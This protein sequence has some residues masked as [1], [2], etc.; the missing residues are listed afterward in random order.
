MTSF[1]WRYLKHNPLIL[2]LHLYYL[3]LFILLSPGIIK[4]AIALTNTH[5]IQAPA[6]LVEL[7]AWLPRD[8]FGVFKKIVA[9][10]SVSSLL[11]CSFFPRSR[12]ARIAVSVSLLFWVGLE[13]SYGKI[14]HGYQGWLFSS[15]ALIFLP[16]LSNY[17]SAQNKNQWLQQA[18]F[19]AQLCAILGYGTAGLWKVWHGFLITQKFGLSTYLQS[20]GNTIAFEHGFHGYQPTFLVNF[21]LDHDGVSAFIFLL[22][23]LLQFFS[24]ILVFFKKSHLLLGFAFVFFHL[25]S[26]II[27]KIPFR[28]QLVLVVLLFIVPELWERGQSFGNEP[29]KKE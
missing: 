6:E 12:G 24:P 15:V 5:F 3:L 19:V 4:W 29:C 20:L 11:A 2:Y 7:L 9:L 14:I 25:G 16:K 1:H 21:L 28:P 26:E 10:S 8:T 27:L 18:F 13:S 23:I 22:L 17:D